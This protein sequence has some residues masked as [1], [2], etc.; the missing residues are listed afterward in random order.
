MGE[1]EREALVLLAYLLLQHGRLE[2]AGTLLAA[3]AEAYPEDRHVPRLLA[4]CL[5]RQGKYPE[6][7]EAAAALC[8]VPDLDPAEKRMAE[9]LRAQALWGLAREAPGLKAE[10]ENSLAAYLRLTEETGGLSRT[11]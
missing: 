1:A 9:L 5:L 4:D 3:L 11:T 7:L 2:K 10:F 6:A 8:A